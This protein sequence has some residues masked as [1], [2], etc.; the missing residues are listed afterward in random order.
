MIGAVRPPG[1][2]VKAGGPEDLLVQLNILPSQT[3]GTSFDVEGKLRVEA[4]WDSS[5]H[6]S[7]LLDRITQPNDHILL[8]VLVHVEVDGCG[9]ALVVRKD[10]KYVSISCERASGRKA[11]GRARVK[12]GRRVGEGEGGPAGGRGRRRAGGRA[13]QKAGG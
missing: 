8:T 13:R 12:A 5:V 2:A 9:E 6:N 7:K 4:A 11:G 10:V 3:S 1:A